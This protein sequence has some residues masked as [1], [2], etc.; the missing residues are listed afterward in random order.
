MY[1]NGLTKQ[2]K[3]FLQFQNSIKNIGEKDSIYQPFKEVPEKIERQLR[4]KKRDYNTVI[5]KQVK[6]SNYKIYQ[7]IIDSND[8]DKTKYPN[9]NDFVIK[10][11]EPFKQ[12]FGI[13]LLKSEL[14]YT[15]TFLGKGIY[16]YLNNYKLIYR[17]ETQDNVNMFAR[18]NAGVENHNCVTTNILDDPFSYILNPLE[19]KLQRFEVKFYDNFNT[20]FNDTTSINVVLHLALFCYTT[21]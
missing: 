12:V 5:P 11:T 6:L 17:N 13:R 10:S 18:I 8:R 9:I 3:Q 21:N 19:P 2:Q 4:D 20:L 16:V 1:Q 14:N 15:S 7:F